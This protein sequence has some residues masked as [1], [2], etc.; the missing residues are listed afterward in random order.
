MPV[1]SVRITSDDGM[2]VLDNLAVCLDYVRQ[3][4]DDWDESFHVPVG[5]KNWN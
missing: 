2:R 1:F 3:G 5:S 4:S